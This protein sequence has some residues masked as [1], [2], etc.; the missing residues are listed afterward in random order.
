M[1]IDTVE[2][3]RY[4]RNPA[5]D[6]F[7]W[8]R[9]SGR[10]G[11]RYSIDRTHPVLRALLHTGC[12]HDSILEQ[13]IQLI[14]RTI[15]VASMLQEPSKSLDGA[16]T[17][18]T[19]DEIAKLAAMVAHAEQFLIRAGIAPAEARSQVLAADPFVR[20]RT[21]ILAYFDQPKSKKK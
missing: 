4:L 21:Q 15:P 10:A 12:N 9:D 6:R 3:K 19:P 2:K 13:A 17:L 16:V 8:R 5:P 20:V 14:E 11:V 7:I 18:D 1:F